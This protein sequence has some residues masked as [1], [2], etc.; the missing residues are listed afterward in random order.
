MAAYD[1]SH[2]EQVQ[3]WRE[4]HIEKYEPP[5]VEGVIVG[6][7]GLDPDRK[8]LSETE[9]AEV[10]QLINSALPTIAS[11]EDFETMMDEVFNGA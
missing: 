1:N 5:K 9:E 7:S 10:S 2:N 3:K 11:D 4:E 8:G 6:F